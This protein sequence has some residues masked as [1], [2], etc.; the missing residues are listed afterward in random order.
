[1]N[2]SCITCLWHDNCICVVCE[3]GKMVVCKRQHKHVNKKDVCDN[4]SI[5]R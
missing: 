4:Y 3:S 2:K 1:M 5:N